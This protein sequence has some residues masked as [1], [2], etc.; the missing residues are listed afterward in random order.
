MLFVNTVWQ[1]AGKLQSKAKNVSPDTEYESGF[2][3]MAK[4]FH[5][6]HKCMFNLDPFDVDD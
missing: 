2:L 3:Y 4:Y 5:F 1:H 6:T